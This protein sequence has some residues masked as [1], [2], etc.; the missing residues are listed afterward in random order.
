[1]HAGEIPRA[2]ASVFGMWAWVT[3]WCRLLKHEHEWVPPPAKSRQSDGE[4]V[5]P[6]NLSRV[7]LQ[8]KRGTSLQKDGLIDE[9]QTHGRRRAGGVQTVTLKK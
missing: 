6:F 4:R 5:Q 1:M 3:A 9:R 7:V 8:K 2:F